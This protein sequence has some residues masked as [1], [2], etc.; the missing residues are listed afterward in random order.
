MLPVCAGQGRCTAAGTLV[1][2]RVGRR[3]HSSIVE[4]A[5]Q[6]SAGLDL[7]LNAPS[8]SVCDD[9]FV[10]V[11]AIQPL[12]IARKVLSV[13]E[14]PPFAIIKMGRERKGRGTLHCSCHMSPTVGAIVLRR[15]TAVEHTPEVYPIAVPTTCTPQPLGPP[16]RNS[17]AI[18]T[19]AHPLCRIL[20]LGTWGN[21]DALWSH[22]CRFC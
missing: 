17:P 4:L 6:Y 9:R 3:V 22:R 2:L 18:P 13:R 19:S 7:Q 12:K 5:P 14:L 10:C 11:A 20:P 21:S 1:L 15:A 8:Q 16:V